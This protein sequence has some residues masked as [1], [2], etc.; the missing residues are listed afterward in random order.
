MYTVLHSTHT[1]D[2][3]NGRYQNAANV[4]NIMH[5]FC[6]FIFLL[7]LVVNNLL[8]CIVVNFIFPL[9]N[10][11]ILKVKYQISVIDMDASNID[12]WNLEFN[13]TNAFVCAKTL[14]DNYVIHGIWVITF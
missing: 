12:N 4:K 9:I 1:Y 8:N 13:L 14:R 2:N 3:N 6:A 11:R 10:N 7:K 5:K